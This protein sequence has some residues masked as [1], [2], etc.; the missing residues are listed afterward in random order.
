VKDDPTRDEIFESVGGIGLK[1]PNEQVICDYP[2]N[3]RRGRSSRNEKRPGGEGVKK[4]LAIGICE[5][6][7]LAGRCLG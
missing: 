4:Q 5:K 1:S 2:L 6:D 3:N 7:L